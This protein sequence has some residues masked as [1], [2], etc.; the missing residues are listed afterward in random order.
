MDYR[1][2]YSSNTEIEDKFSY[3]PNRYDCFNWEYKT[4]TT[5][6]DYKN[7]VRVKYGPK[8][9]LQFLPS[10]NHIKLNNIYYIYMCRDGINLEEIIAKYIKQSSSPFSL[11]SSPFF[12]FKDVIS[13]EILS[14]SSF[15][16]TSFHIMNSVSTVFGNLFW[17]ARYFI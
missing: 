7:I 3:I 1:I 11:L 4:V 16:Y 15:S 6:K 17:A 2:T 10:T 5:L 8:Q 9:P 12:E 14:L 13:G